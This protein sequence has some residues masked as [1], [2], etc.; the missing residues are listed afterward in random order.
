L[1][2]LTTFLTTG[3]LL[4][5][6]PSAILH[7][8]TP[9]APLTLDAAIAR[10][11]E[12]NRAIVAARLFRPVSAAGVGVASERLNPDLTY[13]AERETPKQS[14]TF[15]LPIE[16]GGKR[17]RR[18][19]VAKANVAATDADITRLI[20]EI[21]ND[22]RRAYYTV[23]AADRRVTLANESRALALRVRDTAATRALAGD[24]PQLEAV[25]TQ[26]GLS[27][28]DQDVTAARGEAA[29]ARAELNALIGLPVNTAITLTDGLTATALPEL[30]DLVGQAREAN[31]TLVALDRR[32]AEQ[33]ARRALAKAMKVPDMTASGA[34]T[35]DAQP[36]FRVGWRA[37]GGITLPIF[38]RHTAGV[39]LEDAE[40]TRLKAD[41][42]ATL[43]TTE[44]A[45][46]AA[47]ARAS[48]AREQMVRFDN[49]ILPNLIRSE[50]M[51][52][53]GYSAGQTRLFELLAALQQTRES[54]LKGLQ[55]ALDFQIAM[56]DLE[57]AVGTRLR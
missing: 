40:L 34:I 28:A 23:V 25:Q 18:V 30:A 2:R 38:T 43:A 45:V 1:V 9:N 56:A 15:T 57:R 7:A 21:Q 54:R 41:R 31:S 44:G 22:V 12:N 33:G 14:F 36:E 46:A 51:V 52:Q 48:A 20:V 4:V 16:L 47:L 42:D 32:I 27:D 53:D 10:A 49:E 50:Q 29:A 13:E 35:Y 8:Q 55:A 37:S 3:Y 19:D 39:L 17:D 6:A 24:V 26:I 5:S 11:L